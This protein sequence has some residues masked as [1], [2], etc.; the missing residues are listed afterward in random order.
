M[1]LFNLR[2][3]QLERLFGASV[4]ES[5]I[6]QGDRSQSESLREIPTNAFQRHWVPS[7]GDCL[8]RA[9]LMG[10]NNMPGTLSENDD[11]LALRNPLAEFVDA[12]REEL[13]QHP[14]VS[15]LSGGVDTLHQLLTNPGAW[16]EDA[17]DLVAPL[18]AH[19]LGK[20]I[21]ILQPIGESDSYSEIAVLLPNNTLIPLG[22]PD[23][24]ATPLYLARIDHN[25][26]EFLEPRDSHLLTSSSTSHQL[27][28]V[29]KKEEGKESASHKQEDIPSQLQD[30][31][32]LLKANKT[33]TALK[34]IQQLETYLD[35]LPKNIRE[36]EAMLSAYV[37]VKQLSAATL[38]KIKR[39][40]AAT[41]K[42]KELIDTLNNEGDTTG[43]NSSLA[44]SKKKYSAG[45][46]K[47]FAEILIESKSY[48]EAFEHLEQAYVQSPSISE[49]FRHNVDVAKTSESIAKKSGKDYQQAHNKKVLHQQNE[50]A[51]KE[52]SKS[53]R[54]RRL[55]LAV[56]HLA[57]KNGYLYS[58]KPS[59]NLLTVNMHSHRIPSVV[60][61][62][63]KM[64]AAEA[65]KLLSAKD[66]SKVGLDVKV[67]TEVRD[68]VVDSVKAA[69][70]GGME[71]GASAEL[72]RQKVEK[73]MPFAIAG[74]IYQ[75]L[76]H[77]RE[78]INELNVTES[79]A[80]AEGT[81]GELFGAIPSQE[82][83]VNFLRLLIGNAEESSQALSIAQVNS[84]ALA[85]ALSQAVIPAMDVID[86]NSDDRPL[87][88]KINEKIDHGKALLAE[89]KNK[90]A[91]TFFQQAEK[92]YDAASPNSQL[93]PEIKKNIADIHIQSGNA[94]LGMGLRGLAEERFNKVINVVEHVQNNSMAWRVVSSFFN[95]S[96][97]A[98][99]TSPEIAVQAYKGLADTTV[100]GI[101]YISS[102]DDE[103]QRKINQQVMDLYEKAM[104]EEPESRQS[105]EHNIEVLMARK[106]IARKAK[107]PSS[108][109][110]EI[111]GNLKEA[112]QQYRDLYNSRPQV[113]IQ[114]YSSA[115]KPHVIIDLFGGWSTLEKQVGS[116]GFVSSF[117]DELLSQEEGLQSGKKPAP[118]YYKRAAIK[119]V[120]NIIHE[121]TGDPLMRALLDSMVGTKN[122][123]TLTDLA[124][125]A[126]DLSNLA[127]LQG[128]EGL[129]SFALEMASHTKDQMI[130]SMPTSDQLQQGI[131][132]VGSGVAV[133]GLSIAIISAEIAAVMSYDIASK[134]YEQL[135]ERE[136]VAQ[137]TTEFAKQSAHATAEL[138][139][140]AGSKAVDS[141]SNRAQ[142]A[143]GPAV[144]ITMNMLNRVWESLP[145][146]RG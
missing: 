128:K 9:V 103:T 101:K 10:H 5:R 16:D 106:E 19:V 36:T 86:N 142:E 35:R 145:T 12:H 7:D 13:S 58:L 15:S 23:T 124:S 30:V 54:F 99:D 32:K 94:L 141:L 130:E 75:T 53:Q 41:N 121:L 91:L 56:D 97:E 78:T 18:L 135:P 116:P 83:T 129:K 138:V 33:K 113:S 119:K 20:E 49:D 80:V 64:V 46:H 134:V 44:E 122:G 125:L 4:G 71:D 120:V 115:E 144:Q 95:A 34:T 126:V 111:N 133:G 96:V 52:S 55:R 59:K 29:E 2:S 98:V 27:T 146:I 25:H 73:I 136:Q 70:S 79:I 48:R 38:A 47:Q 77:M 123:A 6:N 37:E 11:V 117:L 139:Y 43:V 110:T 82:D 8:F 3:H 114:S 81:I 127:S 63:A 90:Q 108:I 60:N 66:V 31:R 61:S 93:R 40:V 102:K 112:R 62:I 50:L 84:G 92:L 76:D 39:P 65:D 72:I 85:Q 140:S 21:H 100:L 57:T 24:Q 132:Q 118:S 68:R 69:V 87:S 104:I 74:S 26:Y 88:I 28:P 22:E 143:Y 109:I 51:H 17:G 89:K 42:L 131:L 1:P 137:T 67:I 14:A 105:H 45:A 107:M